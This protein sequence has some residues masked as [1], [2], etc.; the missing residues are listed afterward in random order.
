MSAARY[1]LSIA[2]LFEALIVNCSDQQIFTGLAYALCLRYSKSCTVTAYHYNN[3]TNLLQVSCATHLMAVVLSRQFWEHIWVGA[4]HFAVTGYLFFLTGH[5]L[6]SQKSSNALGFPTEPPLMNVTYS[7]M[8][9]PTACIQQPKELILAEFEKTFKEIYITELEKDLRLS[10]P[11]LAPLY[12]IARLLSGIC[13][14]KPESPLPSQ[15]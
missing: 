5:L 6:S 15:S 10:A 3:V 13:S 7:P 12:I 2:G 9:L 4:S 1:R 8:L 11:W 14:H